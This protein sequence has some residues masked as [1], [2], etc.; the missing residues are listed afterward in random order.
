VSAFDFIYLIGSGVAFLMALVGLT[1]E[2]KMLPEKER[3]YLSVPFCSVLC[4]VL[5]WALPI[6][7]IGFEIYKRLGEKK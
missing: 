5:S 2:Y 7:W 3:C 4:A 1:A 6:W